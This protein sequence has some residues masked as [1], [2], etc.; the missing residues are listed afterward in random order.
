M[1]HTQNGTI[2]HLVQKDII[3]FPTSVTSGNGKGAD[4]RANHRVQHDLFGVTSVHLQL[5]R[6]RGIEGHLGDHQGDFDVIFGD[7]GKHFGIKCAFV[8]C[9]IQVHGVGV[10]QQL[11]FQSCA[12]SQIAT[13]LHGRNIGFHDKGKPVVVSH[14]LFGEGFQLAITVSDIG[15]EYDVGVTGSHGQLGIG[16]ERPIDPALRGKLG[17][18][19]FLGKIEQGAQIGQVM[20]EIGLFR[21][22][23]VVELD[24][25]L[26]EQSVSK[27]VDN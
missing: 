15:V 8:G 26:F 17:C 20:I 13:H 18:S 19:F 4:G 11:H 14:G 21:H 24:I 7:G 22:E 1:H 10:H 16:V 25:D 12:G 6:H 5:V 23:N 2:R 9:S 3:L 27:I